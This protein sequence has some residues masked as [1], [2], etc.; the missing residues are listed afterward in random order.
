MNLGDFGEDVSMEVL[1]LAIRER[2]EEQWCDE[3]V[4]ALG[5]LTPRQAAADPTRRDS[6]LRLLAEFDS[7]GLDDEDDVITMRPDRLRELLDL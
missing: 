5:G 2:L 3:E 6:L 1:Q 7:H 4:P